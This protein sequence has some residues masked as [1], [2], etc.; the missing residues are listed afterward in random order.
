MIFLLNPSIN[1]QLLKFDPDSVIVPLQPKILPIKD[2]HKFESQ[3]LELAYS[4]IERE[5]FKYIFRPSDIIPKNPFDLDYRGSSYYVPR[6]VR[7]ELNLIMNRSREVIS[8]SVFNVAMIALQ[9]AQKYLLVLPKV[10]IHAD[11]I[12]N[13]SQDFN[14][15]QELWKENPQ[16]LSE[17]YEKSAL[18]NTLTAKQL[19]KSIEL[20]TDNKLIKIKTIPD[21][22]SQYFPAMTKPQMLNLLDGCLADTTCSNEVYEK[23]RSLK[24]LLKRN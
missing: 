22:E 15:I 21:A 23:F 16:T 12:L 9:L 19:Q 13:A 17:L 4:K 24:K 18:R 1:A 7:D 10:T 11:N 2:W 6:R 5:H 8:I 3:K 14:I 20:L